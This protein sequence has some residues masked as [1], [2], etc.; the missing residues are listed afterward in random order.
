MVST[1]QAVSSFAQPDAVVSQ[2]IDVCHLFRDHVHTFA[3]LPGEASNFEQC[4]SGYQWHCEFQL[5]DREPGPDTSE[6]LTPLRLHFFLGDT[7]NQPRPVASLFLTEGLAR[8][9]P[10]GRPVHLRDLDR[11]LDE[12]NEDLTRR[13]ELIET[14]MKARRFIDALAGVKAELGDEVIWE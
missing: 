7:D 6:A 11:A 2:L 13:N 12:I 3:R 14:S 4:G 10:Q 8:K 5:R 1:S 9:A